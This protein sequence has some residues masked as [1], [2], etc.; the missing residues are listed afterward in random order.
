MSEKVIIDRERLEELEEIETNIDKIRV[1]YHSSYG[2]CKSY[3]DINY[4]GKDE[5]VSILKD[6]IKN[7]NE[8]IVELIEKIKNVNYRKELIKSEFEKTTLKERVSF[9]NKNTL[10]DW[11]IDKLEKYVY[12]LL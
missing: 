12:S 11:F 4:F 8:A 7:S 5:A 3:N 1:T 9:L 2:F 6:E 10:K